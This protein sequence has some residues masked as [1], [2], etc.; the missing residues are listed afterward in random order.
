MSD[1]KTT[2]SSLKKPAQLN[3]TEIPGKSGFNIDSR[4]RELLERDVRG[5]DEEERRIEA[6][7][8]RRLELFKADAYAEAFTKGYQDGQ[9]KAEGEQKLWIEDKSHEVL[10]MIEWMKSLRSRILEQEW[11]VL[12]KAVLVLVSRLTQD[13]YAQDS[14]HLKKLFLSLL[15]EFG[16]EE[17]VRVSVHPMHLAAIHALKPEVKDHFES[18][19]LY[20]VHPDENLT[21]ADIIIETDWQRIDATLS[22]RIES[23]WT[24]KK[25]TST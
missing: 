23:L 12:Y 1:L 10:P 25:A 2:K 9:A 17:V 6:E 3:I 22:K 13:V 5:K 20:L 19:R 4:V 7:I 11:N 8:Q 14:E 24:Q 16:T 15:D 21:P 18:V